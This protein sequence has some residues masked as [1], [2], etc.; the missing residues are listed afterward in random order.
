MAQ[1]LEEIMMVSVQLISEDFGHL[2][3]HSLVTLLSG[4]EVGCSRMTR[5]YFLGGNQCHSVIRHECMGQRSQCK[6]QQTT[7]TK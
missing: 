2:A 4:I 7:T 6:G 3:A 5:L 1:Q